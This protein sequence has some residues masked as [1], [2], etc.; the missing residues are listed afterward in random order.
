[1]IAIVIPAYQP[2]ARLL[3][4]VAEL[5][6]ASDL[7][8]VVVDDGSSHCCADLFDA[9]AD[10]PG[11]TLLRH[12]I[13][14]GKGAALK[15]AF[16]HCLCTYEDLAGVVT[17]DAD[18]QHLCADVLRVAEELEELPGTLVLGARDFN[19]SASGQRPPLRSRFGN[20]LTV[21]IMRVVAGHQL[22]D[23][24]TGLRGIPALL[25]PP[26]L[27]ILAN[28]YDFELDML[29]VARLREIPI[30]EIPIETVYIDCNRSSHFNPLTDSLKIYFT[31]LRFSLASIVTTLIDNS[32]FF[33]LTA[34]FGWI[35]WHAQAV[36]RLTAMLFSYR[37]AQRA[38]FLKEKGTP[39]LFLKFVSLVV[40]SGLLSFAMLTLLRDHAGFA[41]MPAKLTAETLLFFVNFLV[42]RDFIFATRVQSA[43]AI[44][45]V[46]AA[47]GARKPAVL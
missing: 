27:R 8:I 12:A 47:R 22:S 25:L 24:Q 20:R 39:L 14:L 16:N 35:V 19:A 37:A 46:H 44:R 43:P 26:M 13:N 15:T 36:A 40:L 38:V 30:V 2:D 34:H 42:Q 33:L 5:R 23:T 31:L 11:V 3:A 28:G 41:L 45:R 6:D 21:G 1:V 18:G 4:L 32:I 17:A 10:L 7:P 29:L 9:I